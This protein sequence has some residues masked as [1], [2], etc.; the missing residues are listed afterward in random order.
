ELLKGN[1]DKTAWEGAIEKLLHDVGIS[2][3][4]S[5]N[6]YRSVS[7]Y[8]NNNPLKSADGR[9]IKL[10]YLEADLY[11][12]SSRIIKELDQDSIAYK[13][14][15]KPETSFCDWLEAYIQRSFG[16]YICT[17][18]NGLPHV[19]FGITQQGLIK[20]G[21]IRHTKDDRKRIDDRRNYVLGWSNTEKIKA[22]ETSVDKLEKKI[23]ELRSQLNNIEG[24]EKK[25]KEQKQLL[26]LL[27]YVRDFSR[28]NWQYHVGK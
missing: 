4:V 24:Q 14:D 28:I 20:S 16:D 6:H 5:K 27:L 13:I 2:L 25:N 7:T 11:N 9:G 15:I 23:N 8:V 3:L 21:R 1:E 18:V 10:T 19:P 12:N 17:D 26:S 22:L